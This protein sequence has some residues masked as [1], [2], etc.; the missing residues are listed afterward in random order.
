MRILLSLLSCSALFFMIG[1]QKPKARELP[2]P[3]EKKSAKAQ[4]KKRDS[5]ALLKELK[6]KNPFRPGH[7]AK[8]APAE[9]QPQPNAIL[10][11]IVWDDKN[12]FAIIGNSIIIEGDYIDGKKVKRIEENAVVF[13]IDGK[14]E[15]VKFGD[16]PDSQG[17]EGEKKM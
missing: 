9:S 2:E 11:G 16:L 1:C 8:Q 13:E 17:P 14:E 7:R 15:I 12:P 6:K 10:K 3:K 5:A 4:L